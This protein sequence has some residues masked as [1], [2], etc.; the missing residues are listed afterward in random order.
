MLMSQLG[1]ATYKISTD[2]RLLQNGPQ[3]VTD[4]LSADSGLGRAS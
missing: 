1:L 2:D 4:Q 3:N